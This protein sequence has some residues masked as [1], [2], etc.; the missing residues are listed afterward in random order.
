[1]VNI[2]CLLLGAGQVAHSRLLFY[3]DTD[4]SGENQHSEV[5]G[6]KNQNKF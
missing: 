3:N 6:H 4:E 1:M 5:V 2:A